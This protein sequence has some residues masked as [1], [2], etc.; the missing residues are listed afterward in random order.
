MHNT[1]PNN[2]RWVIVDPLGMAHGLGPHLLLRLA[3]HSMWAGLL[4]P[5]KVASP[6]LCLDA[7]CIVPQLLA[8]HQARHAIS[9]SLAD[10]A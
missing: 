9:F 5:L 8:W 4:L 2:A 7:Q 6:Y 1:A 3:W 10:D